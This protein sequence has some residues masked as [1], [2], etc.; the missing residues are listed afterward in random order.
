MKHWTK[1]STVSTNP[2][3]IDTIEKWCY[4]NDDNNCTNEWWLYTWYEAMWL[5]STQTTIT[6]E[7]TAKSVCWQ[8]WIWWHLPSDAD[9]TALITAWATWWTWN[10]LLWLIVSYL[11]GYRP[12]IGSSY[13]SIYNNSVLWSSNWYNSTYS[14]ASSLNSWDSTINSSS[15]W[16]KLTWASLFCIKN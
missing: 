6:T 16:N 9:H 2:S 11:W 14:L 12:Y 10:K 5:S 15:T 3:D 4:N 13:S 7:D 8:L 1:L